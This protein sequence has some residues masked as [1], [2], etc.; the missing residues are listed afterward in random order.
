MGGDL[1]EQKKTLLRSA[2][3]IIIIAVS[4]LFGVLYQKISVSV[5]K[6]KYPIEFQDSVS[7]CS[8]RFSVA[9]NVIF[10]VIKNES[11]FDSSLLSDDGRIGLMQISS[12]DFET[13]KAALKD[14]YDIGMMYDPATNIKYGTY[15][16]S[17]MYIRLG[18]W[19]AVYA[20]MVVGSDT[21]EEWLANDEYAEISE[22]S[23]PKLEKIPD[24]EADKFVKKMTDT[25]E[26][27]KILYY[28]D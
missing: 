25:A 19:K 1:T 17:S 3:I 18:S 13:A 4:V 2:L 26:K 23:K 10:A 27:Y 9:E 28:A 8:E 21:V 24:K 11:D 12:E 6:S 15:L 5:D 20:A 16:L 14:N 22:N 7:E